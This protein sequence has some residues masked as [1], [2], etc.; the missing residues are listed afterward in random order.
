MTQSHVTYIQNIKYQVKMLWTAIDALQDAQ[1][2]WNAGN[3]GVTLETD[4]SI[5]KEDVGAVVFDTADALDA[6]LD[7][8]HAGNLVKLL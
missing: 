7:G 4:G 3:Y 1:R 5:T 2:Q 8:G 6:L